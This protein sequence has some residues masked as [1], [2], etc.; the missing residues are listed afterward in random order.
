MNNL[1]KAVLGAA[2]IAALAVPASGAT[3]FDTG[4]PTGPGGYSVFY[5]GPDA[6]QGEAARFTLVVPTRI[7][8]IEAYFGASAAGNDEV[9]LTLYAAGTTIPGRPFDTEIARRT[10]TIPSTGPGG[11]FGSFYDGPLLAAG[12]Y[13]VTVTV[14]PGNPNACFCFLLAGG[15]PQNIPFGAF[16]NNFSGNN[17]IERD[18]EFGFR[19]FG[20]AAAAVPEPASW[21][22]M[23]AGFGIVGSIARRRRSMVSAW[24]KGSTWSGA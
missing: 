16:N 19:V 14:D 10:V 18:L 24:S 8:G 5:A 15:A 1:L 2:A 9:D 23:I 17:W 20:D 21:G 7:T 22:L 4:T 13:W 6:Y 11:W 12:D 3:I